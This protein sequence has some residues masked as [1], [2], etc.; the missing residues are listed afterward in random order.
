MLSLSYLFTLVFLKLLFK[1]ESVMMWVA[2]GGRI[3]R[4][5]ST[6]YRPVCPIFYLGNLENGPLPLS[7]VQ[8]WD[9][10]SSQKEM[11]ASFYSNS[12]Y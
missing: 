3:L 9:T 4:C 12:P 1:E 7:A 8:I 2:G 5:S 11:P 10:N 6:K